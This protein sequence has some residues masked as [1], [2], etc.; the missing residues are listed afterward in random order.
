MVHEQGRESRE[1]GTVSPFKDK[2]YNFTSASSD[3]PELS[4]TN[5]TSLQ[6]GW[7]IKELFNL[8]DPVTR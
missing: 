1:G 8:G 5:T 3:W 4:Q 2:T 6:G 7:T